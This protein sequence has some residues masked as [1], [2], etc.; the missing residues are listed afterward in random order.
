[1][2]GQHYIAVIGYQGDLGEV[3]ISASGPLRVDTV[4][5]IMVDFQ[6]VLEAEVG[7]RLEHHYIS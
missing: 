2:C 1:M 5:L 4:C 3:G 7:R 6:L